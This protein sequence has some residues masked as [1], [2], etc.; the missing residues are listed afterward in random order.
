MD[1]VLEKQEAKKHCYTCRGKGVYRIGNE[2][3]YC[4]CEFGKKRKKQ[5]TSKFRR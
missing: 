5:E 1:K 3:K 2:E 4:D